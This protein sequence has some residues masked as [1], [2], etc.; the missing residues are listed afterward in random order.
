[1]RLCSCTSC[2]DGCFGIVNAFAL[3]A[4]VVSSSSDSRCSLNAAFSS[5]LVDPVHAV[6]C[7]GCGSI[8][9]LSSMCRGLLPSSGLMMVILVGIRFSGGPPSD[10]SGQ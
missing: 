2:C 10:A 6:T 1:M 8:V 9:H 5:K 4:C 7:R 3:V